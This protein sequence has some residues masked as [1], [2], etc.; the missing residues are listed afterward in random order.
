MSSYIH[1]LSKIFCNY[2]TSRYCF[3][4]ILLILSKYCNG[5]ALM[6]D[7][8]PDFAFQITLLTRHIIYERTKTIVLLYRF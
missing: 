3:N 8:L 5:Y 2:C 7:V 1:I 6:C 4:S